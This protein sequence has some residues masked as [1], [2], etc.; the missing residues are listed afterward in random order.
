[1]RYPLMF[2]GV[3]LWLLV[4]FSALAAPENGSNAAT[5]TATLLARSALLG[6]QLSVRERRQKGQIATLTMSCVEDLDASS[7][8]PVYLA[9]LTRE[10]G[11]TVLAESDAFFRTPLGEKVAKISLLGAY[12]ALKQVP[13]EPAPELTSAEQDE[14][15]I[16]IQTEAGLKLQSTRGFTSEASRQSER[17]AI[18]ELAQSCGLE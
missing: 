15:A 4:A 7:L 2:A 6:M 11:H 14:L 18:L 3:S 16:F 10:W 5:P 13:P 8:T 9:S 17:S 12:S 1:M